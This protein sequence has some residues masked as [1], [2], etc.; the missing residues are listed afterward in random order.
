MLLILILKAILIRLMTFIVSGNF[1]NFSQRVHI[2][3]APSGSEDKPVHEDVEI[4][5]LSGSMASV[6][7]ILCNA[8]LKDITLYADQGCL[9]RM[10]AVLGDNLDAESLAGIYRRIEEV[11]CLKTEEQGAYAGREVTANFIQPEIITNIST[12]PIGDDQIPAN[13]IDVVN[14]FRAQ[15]LPVVLLIVDKDG[16]P[17]KVSTPFNIDEV[18][19]DARVSDEYLRAEESLE[20]GI[21]QFDIGIREVYSKGR[22]PYL[23]VETANFVLDRTRKHE[24]RNI[25]ALPREGIM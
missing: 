3:R 8:G 16:F 21:G 18:L 17:T 7:R 9:A 24:E 6:A 14:Y 22:M 10:Q 5:K 25:P 19:S 15:S 4:D 2:V 13:A 12:D 20:A 11:T 1:V 23:P